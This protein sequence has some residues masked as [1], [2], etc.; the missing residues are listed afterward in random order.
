MLKTCRLSALCMVILLLPSLLLGQSTSAA[1]TGQVTDP[2][3]AVIPQA[4]ITA[5]N[6]NTNVRYEGVTNNVGTFLI[7]SLPPGEYRVQVEKVGFKS[8][9]KP[10]VTLHVQDTIELNFEMAL[11][12][13]S[14]TITVSSGAPLVNT[15]SAAVSTVIDRN[16]VQNLPLN[17]RSFQTLITLTPG[18]VLTPASLSSGNLGQFS[19]NGQRADANYFSVDGVS[20]NFGTVAS[21]TM[22]QTSGGALPGLSAQGGTNSLVSVDALQEFRVQTSSFAPEF[23]R[24]PGGQI[25]IVTRSGTNEF[26]G[27]LFDY[28]RNDVLDANNWFANQSG[29]RKPRERQNDFGG[30]L[31]GPIIK[32]KTFFFF[33]YEGLR[34]RQPLA[35]QTVVPSLVSRQVA[36]S[37][38]QPFLNAY[39]VPNG[40]DLGNGFAQFGSSFSNP[41]SLDAYSIRVDHVVSSKLYLFGRYSNSPSEVV[42]R[43]GNL[44]GVGTF[45]ENVQTVTTGLIYNIANNTTNELRLNYSRAKASNTFRIDNFGGAVAPSEAQIPF[46]SGFSLA[47]SELLFVLTGAGNVAIG[48]NAVNKQRQINILDNV[49]V[50]VGAHQL[51]FGMDYRWLSPVSGPLAYL[52]EPIFS[53]ITGPRGATSGV[54]QFTVVQALRSAVL[55]SQN[56]SFYG[57]DTWKVTPR[58]TLLYGLRWDINPALRGKN[59]NSDPFTVQGLDNPTTLTLAP[60][61]TPLYNTTYGNVAPRIGVSYQLRQH[62]GWDTVLKG[63]FGVFYDLGSGFLGSTVTNF[64]FTATKILTGVPF[65]LTPQQAAPPPFSQAPPVSSI[66]V[67]EPDLALPRTYQ[68]N[69]AV[70]QSLGANQ[71]LSLTY[72]GAIGRDLLRIDRLSR[73]NVNFAS[74]AVVR[75]R[76]TSDYHALQLKF[77]RRVSHGL[78]A[79]ASYTWSH[80]I[81]I[82]SSDSATFNTP[83]A[84][85][86]SLDR[87]NSDFDVRHSMSGAVIYNIPVGG[88]T[89]FAR[90]ILG[91]WSLDNLITVRSA[92]PV[93][94]L[95]PIF[96]TI[97]GTQFQSRPN[98]VSGVPLYLYGTQYPG[99]KAFNP[100]AFV[101]PPLGQQGNLGRNVLRGFGAWQ[102]DLALHRQFRLTERLGLQFRTEFFNIFNHPNFGAPTNSLTS[103]LFGRS[104]QTLASSLGSGG[105]GGGFTSLFQVGGPRSIQFALKFV[106]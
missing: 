98:V 2:A 75:N 1:I 99:G 8:I 86:T 32:D 47:N 64:P 59:G 26:H 33:S 43:G 85:G 79:L 104:T 94:V 88:L 38:I 37:A 23:G 4:K 54:A 50:T 76:A 44:A 57:Q 56:F 49:S 39:P 35:A 100:A 24:T 6:N 67:A 31:G 52:L 83:A 9:V 81:D 102:S 90:A 66:L 16:F 42:S 72:V 19:V 103:P 87:G 17:G 58:L 20:A 13:T 7:A 40:P 78:Q 27:T 97:A 45:S 55:L 41:S 92:L 34:L 95:G 96:T 61:G 12:S 15:E 91:D 28:F 105:L 18:V 25:S 11:G 22:G 89:G 53:G 74:V 70:E 14:E 60:R 106:F 36:P 21:T 3:K 93:T 30:V 73:P 10:D 65:P 5:I 29:A 80:S 71:A 48:K 84:I 77:Q 51:K 62:P 63:G 46:P 101:N 69:T 82:A 68:W